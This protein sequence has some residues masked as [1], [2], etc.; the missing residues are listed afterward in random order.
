MFNVET[1][2]AYIEGY[3]FLQTRFTW[4]LQ[5]CCTHLMPFT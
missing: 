1:T 5:C 4:Q 3:M 2:T